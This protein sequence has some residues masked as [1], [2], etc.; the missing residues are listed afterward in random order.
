MKRIPV[1]ILTGFLGSGKT[2]LLNRI[3]KEN[4]GKKIA[5]IENEFGEIGVDQE[6]VIHGEEEVIEMN[7]GCICCTVRGDLL[8]I[9]K[10]LLKGPKKFDYILI[11]T[12][13]LADPAPVAQTFLTDEELCKK[14]QLEGI[15]TVIDSKHIFQQIDRSPEA[16]EQIAFADV[17]LLNKADLVKKADLDALEG[18]IRSI[19]AVA[20]IHRTVNAELPIQ[21]VL[22]VGGFNL[23]R[24]LEVDPKFLEIEYPFECAAL[25]KLSKGTYEMILKE[26]PDPSMKMFIGLLENDNTKLDDPLLNDVAIQFSGDSA[27]LEEGTT[28]H[29][30]PG[31]YEAVIVKKKNSFFVKIPTDGHLGLFTQHHPTEFS[32]SV[33]DSKGRTLQPVTSRDFKPTHSHDD[34][35]SSV[36]IEFEGEIDMNKLND[37]FGPLLRDFGPDIFRFK[38]FLSI[39]TFETVCVVQG[40]HMLFDYKPFRAFESNEKKKNTIVFIGRNLDRNL[41]TQGF[42]SCKKD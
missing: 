12:T 37:W 21:E 28:I 41:L 32:M 14:V 24:A 5:V 34:E 9:I 1:T 2:T 40:V 10:K 27:V 35:V 7:N 26:G 29:E 16:K 22:H 18:K 11:E 42:L 38:G 15:V 23:D 30:L 8:R 3:L 25:Y 31:F 13:G 20:K 6:L 39:D 36:G 33:K 17:I 19:N 4:H